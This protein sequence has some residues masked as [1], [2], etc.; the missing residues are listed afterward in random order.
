[1]ALT[2]AQ[3]T[4]IQADLAIGAAEDVFTNDELDRLYERASS[5][6]NLAVYYGYRQLLADAAKFHDYTVA[7]S[8]VKRS[9]LYDH[10]KKMVDFWEGESQ[11]KANQV[12]IVGGLKIPTQ[13]PDMPD[14]MRR[15]TRTNRYVTGSTSSNRRSIFDVN[16]GL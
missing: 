2:T 11:G 10:I 4:D 8:S 1:M 12:M 6:Y 14:D 9:Q 3:R 13:R 15:D 16:R 7:N 5:A